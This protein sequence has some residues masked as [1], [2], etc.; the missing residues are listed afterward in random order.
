MSCYGTYDG[1]TAGPAMINRLRLP[2]L[3]KMVHDFVS[4]LIKKNLLAGDAVVVVLGQVPWSCCEKLGS[5]LTK[6]DVHQ[7]D[8]EC[9]PQ[10]QH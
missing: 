6:L 7:V 3:Q 2:E 5:L 10:Q 9:G 1:K 8:Q 4:G